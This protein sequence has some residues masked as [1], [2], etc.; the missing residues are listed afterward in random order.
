MP[1]ITENS[2]LTIEDGNVMGYVRTDKV[3]S[4]V[5]FIICTVEEWEDLPESECEK[6]ARE[7]LYESGVMEWGY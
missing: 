6:V 1:K 7:A 3:G 4:K 2:G 5:T